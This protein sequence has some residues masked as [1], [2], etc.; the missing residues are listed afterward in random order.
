MSVETY[1]NVYLFIATENKCIL[2]SSASSSSS[3]RQ[4]C[5]CF[6]VTC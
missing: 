4:V 6:G 3:F 1:T 5:Y 2:F